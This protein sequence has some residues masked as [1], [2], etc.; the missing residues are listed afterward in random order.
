MSPYLSFGAYR[1]SLPDTF[2]SQKHTLYRFGDPIAIITP[3]CIVEREISS[4]AF[5]LH[6]PKGRS[7]LQEALLLPVLLATGSL[8]T[9]NKSEVLAVERLLAGDTTSRTCSYLLTILT[10]CREVV[11]VF[12]R[13]SESRVAV[14]GCG[15]IGSIA[16]TIIGSLPIASLR[17]FDSDRIEASNFN[18]QL[19][20]SE[21]DIGRHKVEVLADHIRSRSPSL[22]IEE[23]P[24]ALTANDFDEAFKDCSALLFSA[25]EPIGLASLVREWAK[26][27]KLPAVFCGYHMSTGIISGTNI[28]ESHSL[29]EFQQL[30]SN[31]SPSYGPA[32]AMIGGIAVDS[33]ILQIAEIEDGDTFSEFQLR[34]LK[35]NVAG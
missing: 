25:D 21:D 3:S 5:F 32:N 15:G 23:M 31:L 6:G 10:T 12:E 34:S 30:E 26:S 29:R 9:G 14:V 2:A 16:A 20:W 24:I 18:R 28:P 19:F 11:A 8:C 27:R 35:S 1:F 7:K 22:Q 33:L 17:L 13:L 4:D